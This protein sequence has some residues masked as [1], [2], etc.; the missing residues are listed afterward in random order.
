MIRRLAALASALALLLAAACATAPPPPGATGAPALV[1][2]IAIDG[3]PQ[4]QL[5]DYR[6]QLAPAGLRRFLDD[7][8]WFSDAHYGHAHTA[9][10]PGHAVMLTGAY[11]HRTGIVGNDWRDPA[12]GQQVYCVGDAE[13]R[14]I[15][16]A[17]RKLDGTSP[18]NLLVE[19]LGDVLR[20]ANP[21]SKVVAVSAKDRGAILPAG[22]MG[23]A[24]MYQ[25]QTGQFSSSTYYM[26]SHPEWVTRFNAARPADRYFHAQW[27]P[28]LPES[29]YARSLPDNQE[30]YAKGGK[31]PMKMGEGMEAPGPRFYVDLIASPFADQLTLE[32]AAAAVD[33]E[34]LGADQAPDILVLSLS[35][36]DY[37]NHRWSAESR[38]SHDH[39]LHLDRSLAAFFERLD[40]RVGKDRYV[41]VLTADHGFAPAPEHLAAKG[42]PAG[43]FNA[44]NAVA[45]IETELALAFGPGKWVHGYMADAILF[46]RALAR[47]RNVAIDTLAQAARKLLLEE[48]GVGAAYTRAELQAG[49]RAGAPYFD[50]MRRTWHP[51]RSGDV[52][53]ATKRYWIVSSGSGSATTHG[54]PHP[55]DTHV[56]VAF[57]GPG[58][59]AAQR[60]DERADVADIAPTLARVLGVPAPAASEGKVLPVLA[61]R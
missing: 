35:G 13:H 10:G 20:R 61:T 4:R 8:A 45:R 22:R 36:H 55:E 14:Y 27:K 5:I 18:R 57:Y 39:V 23:I 49:S 30:W 51:D 50:P 40:A 21:A 7:G 56:P 42:L 24:Y 33:G 58:R 28:L 1:V 44:R 59:I 11:P 3:F 54:S 38:L 47:E 29:A 16:H 17:T 48:P 34:R 52:Q 46:D 43:R 37:V 2:L 12:T 6:D 60:F 31:L 41:A 25:A 19:S 15:G 32:F 53:V 26:Q 9:T